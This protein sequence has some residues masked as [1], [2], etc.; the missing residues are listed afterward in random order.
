MMLCL[1]GYSFLLISGYITVQ[2][3][4]LYPSYLVVLISLSS[5][6]YEYIIFSSI[7]CSTDQTDNM[8]FLTIFIKKKPLK[9]I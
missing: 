6:S 4:R 7:H 3:T 5:F 2:N 8:I 1:V 9:S